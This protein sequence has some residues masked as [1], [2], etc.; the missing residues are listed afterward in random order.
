M[1]EIKTCEACAMEFDWPGVMREGQEFCC[2]GCATGGECTCPQHHHQYASDVPMNR[3]AA[4]QIGV[5]HTPD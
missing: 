1:A 2:D 4:G 3:A 5:T